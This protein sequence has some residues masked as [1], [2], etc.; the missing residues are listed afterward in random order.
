VKEHYPTIGSSIPAGCLV[1]PELQPDFAG[2]DGCEIGEL[3]NIGVRIT[4][5]NLSAGRGDL[6]A[7][8]HAESG[9]SFTFR[10]LDELSDRLC[11]GL[12][13]LGVASGDRIAFRSANIPEV[14]IV[15]LACWKAGAV[16]VPTPVQ[17][18]SDELRFY[19]D[20]TGATV[21]F[22]GDDPAIF[23]DV[24]A[25]IEYSAV[26]HVVRFGEG[27][28]ARRSD[29]HHWRDLMTTRDDAAPSTP[30]ESVAIIWHTGGTT[31]VPKAIYH[32]HRRVL[33]ASHALAR[34]TRIAPGERWAAATPVGHALGFATHTAW[35]LLHGAT[36]VTIEGFQSPRSVVDAI[37][38]YKVHTFMAIA[39]TWSRML[40][41]LEANP[42]LN[43]TS[44]HRA[45]AMW[46]SG[47]SSQVYDAWKERGLELMNN[48]GCTAFASWILCPDPTH[49]IPR[50]SLGRAVQG[51]E[52]RAV[53]IDGDL[54]REVGAGAIG[55]LVARGVSGLTY[56]N[57]PELQA[58][59]VKDGWVLVDDLIEFD[60]DGNAAYLGRTDYL[61]STAGY[62][63]APVEVEEALAMHPMVREVGVIGAPDPIRQEIVMAFVVPQPHAEASTELRQALQEHVKSNLA[64]YKYPRRI[65]FVE[66]LPRDHVGKLQPAVLRR[67]AVESA[68]VP[69]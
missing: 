68:Q 31:G 26:E 2:L 51:Y 18:R 25:A 57:R 58:T 65:E 39:I 30:S 4:R 34:S 60:P 53:E 67:W 10:Q 20:D 64:P 54:M 40:D 55:R 47:S 9:R 37:E 14:V 43:V 46:Q 61:I 66:A 49:P 5:D 21:L 52:V 50:A 63:V 69:Q 32:T 33:L 28:G 7:V 3:D 11:T 23:E 13:E 48:F 22:V 1:P 42:D 12:L 35:T 15:A 56:W 24:P 36:V 27:D 59:D 19:L 62:K 45:F 44:L 17:L 6:P 29:A 38:R 41:V 8:I 16:V